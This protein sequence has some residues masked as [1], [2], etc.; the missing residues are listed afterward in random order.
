MD[1]CLRW[2]LTIPLLCSAT[3][4]VAATD[5]ERLHRDDSRI[6]APILETLISTDDRG[7]W[8]L[9]RAGDYSQPRTLARFEYGSSTPVSVA[10]IE[11]GEFLRIGITAAG[12]GGVYVALELSRGCFGGCEQLSSLYRRDVQG[13]L[14]WERTLRGSCGAPVVDRNR[15]QSAQSISLLCSGR[16]YRLAGN[17]A[18]QS[19]SEQFDAPRVLDDVDEKIELLDDG[20]T[21]VTTLNG[22]AVVDPDG[23][24]RW[25]RRFTE[26]AES[27]RAAGPHIYLQ[28]GNE[29]AQFRVLDATDGSDIGEIQ[30]PG[31]VG[32]TVVW[33]Q[34]LQLVVSAEGQDQ[35][36]ALDAAATVVSTQLLEAGSSVLAMEVAL[37]D[38]AQS[39]LL[40][41]LRDQNAALQLLRIEA[42]GSRAQST[43]NNAEQPLFVHSAADGGALVTH[44]LAAATHR[45]FGIRAVNRQGQLS[46]P[47]VQ[48]LPT[49]LAG[50][51]TVD[52]NTSE[53]W[54]S[55]LFDAPEGSQS[56]L[57]LSRTRFGDGA[58]TVTGRSALAISQQGA[59]TRPA[60]TA[61]NA[62]ALHLDGQRFSPRENQAH[63][64]CVDRLGTAPTT[65]TDVRL[66]GPNPRL[67]GFAANQDGSSVILSRTSFAALPPVE[68]AQV[69][70]LGQV[71]YRSPSVS[72]QSPIV[73]KP[74]LSGLLGNSLIDDQAE[75]II[76]VGGV[77]LGSQPFN[78]IWLSDGDLILLSQDLEVTPSIGDPL[79]S[80][81]I[82]RLSPTGDVRWSAPLPFPAAISVILAANSEV[83]SIGVSG[84]VDRPETRLVFD[85]QTG[86]ILRTSFPPRP[87]RFRGLFTFLNLQE[88]DG[89][90]RLWRMSTL[91][92]G[93]LAEPIWPIDGAPVWLPCEMD[94]CA[95]RAVAADLSGRALVE[96]E[97][98][99]GRESRT[100]LGTAD[101]NQLVKL[102][103]PTGTP[104]DGIWRR[105]LD[106][107]QGLVVGR[108]P[109]DLQRQTMLVEVNRD[110][111]VGVPGV[112]RWWKLRPIFADSGALDFDLIAPLASDIPR[113]TGQRGSAVRPRRASLYPLA[114]QS[115]MLSLSETFPPPIPLHYTEREFDRLQQADPRSVQVYFASNDH[116]LAIDLQQ[117][118]GLW[119][120][121]NGKWLRLQQQVSG[122]WAI[123]DPTQPLSVD[124]PVANPGPLAV[125]RLLPS[126]CR[127][128][129]WRVM[130]T[131]P[132]AEPQFRDEFRDRVFAASSCDS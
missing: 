41:G 122:D 17:G 95:V 31:T 130:R 80:G 25:Q 60:L 37:A 6:E 91:S 48:S 117:G 12:D 59:I 125:A 78:G 54:R 102:P 26:V 131:A 14:L 96:L 124:G 85:I 56:L 113:P 115:W 128:L 111:N 23:S 110:F 33:Q 34:Q 46:S 62:C 52:G 40:V 103:A 45:S 74:D 36:I 65:L 99:Q 7:W 27:A 69:N 24:T 30:I 71:D 5:W 119:G 8:A 51:A 58:T 29:A 68:R 123:F 15:T 97:G 21:L 44:V 116:W 67:I 20:G 10:S 11:P 121:P 53:L 19:E 100:H 84:Y 63:V 75:V 86:S 127:Q 88:A 49:R 126:F 81:R 107:N 118:T 83:L 13:Q 114:D 2:I 104:A 64:Y 92:T 101:L 16:V 28:L 70:A 105:D 93:L 109:G 38:P 112:P 42:D 1:R 98:T 77:A 39:A 73:L 18:T 72:V 50:S 61:V 106:A 94:Y 57:Y 4:A 9:A 47:M 82:E 35:L 66:A 32:P 132:G 79:T 22:V 76:D 43:L 3:C 120:R 89:S 108:R 55:G 90:E 129:R 87:Y